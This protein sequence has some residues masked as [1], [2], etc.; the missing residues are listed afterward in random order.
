MD[1]PDLKK[2]TRASQRQI[3][4]EKKR[5]VQQVIE[6]RQA[7]A[8]DRI[9]R[10]AAAARKELDGRVEKA[11]GR[12][13]TSA[14]A[15]QVSLHRYDLRTAVLDHLKS[16]GAELAEH[17][18]GLHRLGPFTFSQVDQLVKDIGEK[19]SDRVGAPWVKQYQDYLR[20]ERKGLK[21]ILA[22]PPVLGEPVREFFEECRSR[23][24]KPEVELYIAFEDEGIQVTVRW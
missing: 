21:K 9:D 22:R 19:E 14:L 15:L 8:A 13:E 18:P 5:L 2:R 6:A 24:L 17:Y 10:S 12:G 16:R 11:V 23:G 7:A 20:S 4:E 3:Q 1:I